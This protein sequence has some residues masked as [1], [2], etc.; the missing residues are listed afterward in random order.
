MATSAPPLD[1]EHKLKTYHGNCHCGA[2]KYTVTAPHID[3]FE[4][5]DCSYCTKVSEL[6]TCRL[7]RRYHQ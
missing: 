7:S 1:P 3:K 4:K 5:C 2:F 6:A